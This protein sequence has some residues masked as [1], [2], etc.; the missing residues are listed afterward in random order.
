MEANNYEDGMAMV[1]VA[2]KANYP[3]ALK[4]NEMLTRAFEN[5]KTTE[6][7]T[8]VLSAETLKESNSGS[9]ESV[10]QASDETLVVY[11]SKEDPQLLM[12]NLMK[13]LEDVAMFNKRGFTG[14]RLGDVKCGQQGSG[15][16]V[17]KFEDGFGYDTF[18]RNVFG[19]R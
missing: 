7:G 17:F 4:F 10:A 13:E 8:I 15:C 11:G 12:V 19:L 14:S 9:V 2:I 16:Q 1:N 18:L 3:P 6:D 5:Q